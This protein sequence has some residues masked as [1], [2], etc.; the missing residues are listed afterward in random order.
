M[1]KKIKE[2]RAC[3]RHGL[4]VVSGKRSQEEM[5]GF[6][7]IVI[8]V[9]II[10]LVIIGLSLGT[11]GNREAVQS[12]EAESFLQATLQYTSN[13][14]IGEYLSVR[15]LIIS[16]N[17]NILCEDGN[18]TCD[19]LDSTLNNAISKSWDVEEDSPVEGYR[20]II[21]VDGTPNP[22][23]NFTAGNVTTNY[24]GTSESFT[25]RSN[26][27]NVIFRVYY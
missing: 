22:I 5:V 27:Y 11:R 14:I 17:D 21:N 4:H 6:A 15:D 8:I 26:D 18:R 16:C 19:V 24:K 12:Y 23:M 13:C 2:T 25:R 10:L 7:L 20:L 1:H 9:A 3:T